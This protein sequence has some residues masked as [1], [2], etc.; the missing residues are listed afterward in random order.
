[1]LFLMCT[2][3][4]IT[5]AIHTVCNNNILDIQYATQ[6]VLIARLFETRPS[7]RYFESLCSM[8]QR[9]LFDPYT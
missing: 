2:A 7:Q 8:Q 9:Y 6:S 5:Q 1:M 3:N 4:D